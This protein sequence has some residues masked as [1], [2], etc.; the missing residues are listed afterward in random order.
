M[1]GKVP[2]RLLIL[3]ALILTLMVGNPAWGE[4]IEVGKSRE[5]DTYYFDFDR[6][7]KNGG[8][9]YIWGMIDLLVPSKTGL[10]SSKT[11][12]QFDCN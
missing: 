8:Y 10:M 6:I 1:L 3:P 4:W 7:K 9:I 2:R 5:G 12:S 11:Y